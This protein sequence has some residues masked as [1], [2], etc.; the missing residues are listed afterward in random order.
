M[1]NSRDPHRLI[2]M[3]LSRT[4]T[5][6]SRNPSTAVAPGRLPRRLL[7]PM[8]SFFPGR[9]MISTGNC[10][11][12]ISTVLTIPQ[13]TSMATPWQP[14]PCLAVYPLPLFS[15]RQPSLTQPRE[16]AGSLVTLQIRI[17][18]TLLSSSATIVESPPAPMEEL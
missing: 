12:A 14:K 2:L 4:P 8:T 7:C 11:L 15:L 18:Q 6:S 9:S 10:A 17:F 13:I 16:L 3:K 1:R 5:S